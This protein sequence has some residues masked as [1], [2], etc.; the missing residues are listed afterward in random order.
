MKVGFDLT[1]IIYKRG[2]SRYTSNLFVA[3]S[4]LADLELYGYASSGRGNK[5][6]KTE[7]E[8][9]ANQLTPEKKA[10]FQQNLKV[11]SI[12]PKINHWLWHYLHLNSLKKQLPMIE[13][14]HS[15]DYLQPPDENLPLVSTIHDVAIAK[16]PQIAN[17]E[18]LKHHQ[19]SW[20]ILKKRRAQVIAPSQ[21]T[22]NDLI[23]L[24]GF[25]ERMVHLV[26]EALP[27]DN[28]IAV[29]KLNNQDIS[30]IRKKFFINKP[31][32]L[33]VGTR[34]PRKN[35]DRLI[36]AWWSQ[37]EQTAL[38]LVGAS[39]WDEPDWQH[40]NLHTLPPVSDYDLAL[41]YHFALALTYPSIDEGFGLPILE[42]F[43]Y[44]TPVLTSRGTATAEVAGKA[45][46]LIDPKNTSEIESGLKKL[47]EQTESQKKNWQKAMREQLEKF[48]WQ[49]AAQETLA[50]YRLAK[51]E[52]A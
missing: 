23:N 33:F 21:S 41:L 36:Q 6:L 39:G 16:Y 27:K 35:L 51:E 43:Y 3:L 7:L 30:V 4:Q 34:E 47:A 22:K 29:D 18:I 5:N 26:Y 42:A 52:Y 14:F 48:S 9:M 44:Q 17:P 10:I 37:R 20:E 45:V 40:P 2:V 32:F 11:Q 46:I 49:K 8:K 31:Y 12:P 25:D 38:V 50:V 1:A 24:L 15:W 13:V 28:L 19:E